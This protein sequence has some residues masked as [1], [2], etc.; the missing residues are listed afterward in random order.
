[1]DV[2][3]E[4]VLMT[5]I[6]LAYAA[7]AKQ[8]T[9]FWTRGLE[10]VDDM[11]NRFW[12]T[13]GPDGA[14]RQIVLSTRRRITLKL[15]P[16]QAKADRTWL[17]GWLLARDK[18]VVSSIGERVLVAL[19]DAAEFVGE[20]IAACELARAFEVKV[21]EAQPLTV[22]PPSFYRWVQKTDPHGVGITDPNGNPV[23]VQVA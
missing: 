7:L 9:C 15:M 14:R 18:T 5:T 23:M 11:V 19:E 1:V 20:W 2:G 17:I 21:T 12:E 16:V 10:D 8:Y 6:S 13:V 4:F 22:I 3:A